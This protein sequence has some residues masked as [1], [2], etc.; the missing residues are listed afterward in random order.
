MGR[1]Q[2]AAVSCES[3]KIWT[4]NVRHKRPKKAQSV[5]PYLERACRAGRK[6]KLSKATFGNVQLRSQEFVRNVIL[7]K[8]H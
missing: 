8:N 2:A 6:D 7:L 5:S 1:A 4:L 3:K